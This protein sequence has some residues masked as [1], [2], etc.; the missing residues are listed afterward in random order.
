MNKSTCALQ[1]TNS[2]L[3][4]AASQPGASPS[5]AFQLASYSH[6]LPCPVVGA[7]ERSLVD[8]APVGVEMPGTGYRMPDAGRQ[9]ADGSLQQLQTLQPDGSFQSDLGDPLRQR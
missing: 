4:G 3:L 1:A 8:A 2:T 6:L 9:L 7:P 5:H